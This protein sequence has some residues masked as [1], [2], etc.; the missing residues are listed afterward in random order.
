VSTQGRGLTPDEVARVLR[1]AAELDASSGDSGVP[2]LVDAALVEEA[3]AEAGLS[4]EAVRQ[5]IDELALE[6]GADHGS[7]LGRANVVVERR[8]AGSV[9]EVAA[10]LHRYLRSQ[11]LQPQRVSPT[12]SRWVP[13]QGLTVVLRRATDLGGRLLLEDVGSLDL[14]VTP[15]GI[16]GVHVRLE[17]DLAAVRRGRNVRLA[18]GAGAGA[19]GAGTVVLVVGAAPAAVLAIPVAAGLAAGGHLVARSY[20]QHRV[21]RVHDALAGEL[22]RI[23]HPAALP[24]AGRQPTARSRARVGQVGPFTSQSRSTSPG[25]AGDHR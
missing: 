19:L 24:P 17:A 13:R 10:H 23:E 2:E 1:R 8:F 21:G 22:D 25:T 3:A 11:L 4:R 16:G 9:E 7:V 6:P 12:R 20:A 14:V 15:T 5:A 18:G